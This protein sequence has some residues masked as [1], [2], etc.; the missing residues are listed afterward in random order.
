M[1]SSACVQWPAVTTVMRTPF[2]VHYLLCLLFNRPIFWELLQ[3]RADNLSTATLDRWHKIRRVTETTLDRRCQRVDW[4]KHSRMFSVSERQEWMEGCCVVSMSADPHQ[5]ER[6]KAR[7]GTDKKVRPVPR[8]N[9]WELLWQTSQVWCP[10]CCPTNSIKALKDDSV[11]NRGQQAAS[12]LPKTDQERCDG[13][14]GLPC[15]L[16]SKELPSCDNKCYWH[17]DSKLPP[18]SH[19]E[20]GTL[21]WQYFLQAGCPSCHPTISIRTPKARTSNHR[22]TQRAKNL[23]TC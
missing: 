10:A 4:F 11:P 12:M 21:L 14:C 6:P 17:G 7:Q 23:H 22:A 15:P 8:V 18:C 20:P 3:A 2:W 19:C 5:C 16:A 1:V 13:L 9:S